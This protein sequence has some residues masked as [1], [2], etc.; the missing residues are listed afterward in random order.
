MKNI[1]A[2]FLTLPP[3]QQPSHLRHPVD[4]GYYFAE[5]VPFSVSEK[6]GITAAGPSPIF[7][8]S[9]ELRGSLYLDIA[10]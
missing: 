1:Q 5:R 7:P 9:E 6:G 10:N 2:G 3:F 4:S 8:P